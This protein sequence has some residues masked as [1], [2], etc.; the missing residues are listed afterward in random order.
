MSIKEEVI[1]LKRR[2]LPCCEETKQKM[3]EDEIKFLED[4][5]QYLDYQDKIKLRL[6]ELKSSLSNHNN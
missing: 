2:L 4:L 1:T 6:E 3:I 5:F